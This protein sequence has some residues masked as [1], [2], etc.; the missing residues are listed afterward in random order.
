MLSKDRLRHELDRHPDQGRRLLQGAVQPAGGAAACQVTATY[1]TTGGSQIIVTATANVKT[2]FMGLMG[3][4]QLK[5]GVD[6]QIKWGN[7]KLRVALVL[8]TTGSMARRRQDDA[9]KTATKGLLDQLKSAAAKD[10]DVYVSIIPFRKDVNVGAEQL[11]GHLD[12][13]DRLGRRTTAAAA[14][15]R[16]G[17]KNGK[18]G[19]LHARTAI[20]DARQPQH[21][22]RL[23][24]RPRQLE[25]AEHRATPTTT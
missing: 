5:I 21:L 7:T 20:L 11:Q 19:C 23:R 14:R 12:R 24:H 6:S 8:D 2:N 9:L 25:R 16:W 4:S 17:T 15:Q 22:E 3:I 1:T 10:G 18:S 13:L